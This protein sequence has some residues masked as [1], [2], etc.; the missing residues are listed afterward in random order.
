MSFPEPPF[1]GDHEILDI[2]QDGMGR[3]G[4]TIGKL[5]HSKL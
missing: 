5:A 4:T 3:E 1:D 2:G